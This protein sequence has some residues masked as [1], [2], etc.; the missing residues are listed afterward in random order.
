MA[1][2]QKWGFWREGVCFPY[3]VDVARFAL[4][5]GAGNFPLVSGL[6]TKGI[7]PCAVVNHCVCGRKEC[8]GLPSPPSP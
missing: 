7:K 6:L 8:S 5:R 2:Y 3:S 4:A 1:L